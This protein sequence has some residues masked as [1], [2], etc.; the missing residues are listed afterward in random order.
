MCGGRH[1]FVDV[2]IDLIP[3]KLGVSSRRILLVQKYYTHTIYVQRLYMCVIINFIDYFFINIYFLLVN[4]NVIACA[5]CDREKTKV[6][7]NISKEQQI[8]INTDGSSSSRS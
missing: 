6:L 7:Y 4:F 8:C 2:L 5:E 3:E 1:D